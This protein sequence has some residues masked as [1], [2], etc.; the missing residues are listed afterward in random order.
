MS[1]RYCKGVTVVPCPVPL[2]P[3]LLL[4]QLIAPLVDVEVR[5]VPAL[6]YFGNVVWGMPG[7]VCKSPLPSPFP[8]IP[9]SPR[10]ST[11]LSGLGVTSHACIA[12]HTRLL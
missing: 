8:A 2:V 6:Q 1:R 12:G 7:Q 11:A 10:A 5:G 3:P 9:Y 4:L